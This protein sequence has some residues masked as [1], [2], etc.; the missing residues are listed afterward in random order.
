MNRITSFNRPPRI[1]E[2]LPEGEVK[3]PGPPD[4]SDPPQ[5]SWFQLLIPLGRLGWA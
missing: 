5:F 4:I 2:P 3:V 1:K